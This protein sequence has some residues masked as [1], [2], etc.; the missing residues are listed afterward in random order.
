MFEV[1]PNFEVLLED[2][3]EMVE[4]AGQI[5]S[6]NKYK[7]LI[8]AGQ[9]SSISNEATAFMN[10]EEAHRFTKKEAI[11]INS[12]AQRILGNFY[13]GIVTKARPT[14]LFNSTEKA[15]YWLNS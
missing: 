15:I 9:F 12:L 3:I 11:V 5:G 6:G 14:K 10:T 8:V 2:V 7:N 4:T 1:K 13:M